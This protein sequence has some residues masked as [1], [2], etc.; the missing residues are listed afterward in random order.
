[1]TTD[2]WKQLKE[3]FSAAL[4]CNSSDRETFIKHACGNDKELLQEVRSLLAAHEQPGPLDN[5]SQLLKDSLFTPLKSQ[6]ING[7]KIGPYTILDELG[8]GGMGSVYLAERTDGQYDRR[9]ALKLL[10]TGFTTETQTRRFLTER[11]ILANLIHKNIARLLDGGVTQDGQ[12][13]F[14][15]EFIDGLPIDQYCD[16]K[17]LSVEKRLQLFS[18]VCNAV[19]YAHRK[20]IVHRDLKPSNIY[21]EDNGTVKLLDFGIAKALK[22][23]EIL[24]AQ[25]PVTK[26]GL[27]PLTPAYASPEQIK[28]ES[29]TTASDIYQLGVM[30][31]ELLTGFTPY[32]ISGRTPSEIEQIICERAPTRPSTAITRIPDDGN[33]VTPQQIC[34]ARKTDP[35]Q[36]QQQLRGELDIIVLKAMHKEPERRYESAD[37][38]ATDI[39]NFLTGKP[40]FAH[41]DSIV[42]RT[43]KFVVRHKLGVSSAIAMFLLIIGYAITI[44]YHSQRTRTALEQAKQEMA[45]A[46]QITGFLMDMFEASDPSESLGEN[47]TARQLL[48]NGV[49]EAEQLQQQPEVQGQ[50]LD[51]TGRV[52][53]NIGEYDKAENLLQRA[54]RLRQNHFSEPHNDIAESLHNLGILY[55][56]NGYYKE[57]EEYLRDALKM[58][59]ELFGDSHE[60]IANT[61][62]SLAIVLKELREFEEA[63][64]LYRQAL[65]M[66]REIYGDE[67][68][69]VAYDLNNL[70]NFLESQ[71]EYR[72]ARE[73]YLESLALYR[74]LLG[75]THPQ[76]AGS[77]TNLGRVSDR[78]GELKEAVDYHREALQIRRTVFDE[79]HP[80]IAESQYQL[81]TSLI[82][83][84]AYEDAEV[85]L[86]QS[87]EIRKSV[88]DSLHPDISQTLNSLGI[89]MRHIENYGAAEQYYRESLKLQQSR[90]GESHS[91]A[92]LTMNNLGLVLIRQGR[93]EE[94]RQFLEQSLDVLL[95]NFDED[96][97]LIVYPLLGIAH[98]YLDTRE[99]GRAEPLLRRSLEIQRLSMGDDHW[100][101][102]LIKS[103]LGRCLTAM[104]KFDDAEPLLVEG[105]ETLAGQL[106]TTHERTYK[107]IENLVSL[108]DEWFRPEK[109]SEYQALLTRRDSL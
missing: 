52:Y 63:E 74:E 33:P 10:R 92:G 24:S 67:H 47:I 39:N 14:A 2:K 93:Y 6:D 4:E 8:H 104:K 61:M 3:I 7:S 107:A 85:Y 1:M 58:E 84:E 25:I 90:L 88:L 29:V 9:V 109:L 42:Y 71:G 30:L 64:P 82:E 102:G 103:R 108:Y 17:K 89:L 65:A 56:N 76:I 91:E 23:D 26:T 106:G 94:A 46:E 98:I 43:R 69:S 15:M 28:G 100:M 54:F 5:S 20:L 38:F 11:Q 75:D 101:V 18:N 13:W 40:V 55:W 59:R 60:S 99:P 35:N 68:E 97:P 66:N 81:G 12:P 77:F 73:Y 70:G 57:A 44:T 27:L 105:Y 87:L 62:T 21:V 83:I 19:Q 72:D 45:K 96:H 49:L 78:M 34:M 37:H 48:E 32:N 80:D 95:Q 51:L 31:Y 86:K 53:M 36:L 41:P 22:P 16:K 79:H 50:M